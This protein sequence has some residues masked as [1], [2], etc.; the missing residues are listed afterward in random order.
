M[1]ERRLVFVGKT[2][3][4][5]TPFIESAGLE[6]AGHLPDDET[7]ENKLIFLANVRHVTPGG[8]DQQSDPLFTIDDSPEELLRA[9]HAMLNDPNEVARQAIQRLSGALTVMKLE[10]NTP[11]D[12]VDSLTG[13]RVVLLDSRKGPY[14]M[15]PTP[16][17]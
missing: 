10:A 17:V 13:I 5:P 9:A 15:H 1:I 4:D 3:S 7:P 8:N 11:S 16:D 2:E 14:P 12:T 6:C